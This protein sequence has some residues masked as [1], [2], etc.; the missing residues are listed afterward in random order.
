MAEVTNELM[1]ELLKR[2][3]A[4]MANHGHMLKELRDRVASLETMRTDLVRIEHRIDNLT[5]R[6]EH[7]EKRFDLV[8]A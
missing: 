3:H 6:F 7:I 1:Y 5:D 4:D 2:I 8:E